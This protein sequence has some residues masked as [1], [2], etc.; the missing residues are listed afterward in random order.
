MIFDL[1]NLVVVSVENDELFYL[2]KP[3]KYFYSYAWGKNPKSAFRFND[4]NEVDFALKTDSKKHRHL[5]VVDLSDGWT[6]EMVKKELN[7]V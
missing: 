4:V 2:Y 1:P 6:I 7:Y 5:L 3:D